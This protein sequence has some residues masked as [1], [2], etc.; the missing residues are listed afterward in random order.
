[1]HCDE[2]AQIACQLTASLGLCWDA[3]DFCNLSAAIGN[4][5]FVIVY[6]HLKRN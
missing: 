2:V 1:M 4:F 5:R 6:S 3:V